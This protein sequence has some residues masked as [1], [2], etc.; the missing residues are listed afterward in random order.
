MFLRMIGVVL[1]LGPLNGCVS[2]SDELIVVDEGYEELMRSQESGDSLPFDDI[3]DI[4]NAELTEG[5]VFIEDLRSDM[6]ASSPTSKT[7]PYIHGSNTTR[8][9]SLPR[10]LPE[11]RKSPNNSS[12][13]FYVT[14][15][16]LNVRR[17]PSSKSA[18]VKKLARGQRVIASSRKGQWV[19]IGEEQYVLGTYLSSSVP[20]TTSRL[21]PV[22][23]SDRK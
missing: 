19:K 8:T 2:D 7:Q 6:R 1:A 11:A 12:K 18:V 22:P 14:S 13:T 20:T 10:R 17:R 9:P 15:S 23:V 4:P 5:D 16:T 3:E 21:R